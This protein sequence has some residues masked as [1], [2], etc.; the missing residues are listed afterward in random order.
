MRAIIRHSKFLRSLIHSCPFSLFL[1]ETWFY[2]FP[3]STRECRYF[4]TQCIMLALQPLAHLPC[5]PPRL[6]S[7]AVCITRSITGRR[8]HLWKHR[9]LPVGVL[10]LPMRRQRSK[11]WPLWVL[12]PSRRVE[13]RR[14]I[15]LVPLLLLL[16]L[17]LVHAGSIMIRDR[18]SG[19]RFR[20]CPDVRVRP[21]RERL[22]QAVAVLLLWHLVIWRLVWSVRRDML[23]I[24][25]LHVAFIT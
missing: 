16:M 19:R 12:A 14:S 15:V 5:V 13:H 7:M 20:T 9:A 1:G 10:G 6:M 24:D 17:L 3:S 4:A 11:I 8:L 25:W 23:L 21:R 22:S 2:R 18:A